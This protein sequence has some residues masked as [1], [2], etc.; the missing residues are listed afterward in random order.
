MNYSFKQFKK[1]FPTDDACLEYIF[2]NRYG[3]NY[4]CPRCG[5]KSFYRVKNRKCYAC[6]CGYQVSPTTETIFHKSD[7]KL[8]DWF[9]AIYLMSQSNNG[10]SAKEIQKHLGTT[11]KTAWRIAKLIRSLME[12]DSGMLNKTVEVDEMYIGGKRKQ[13]QR[14][15]NKSMVIGMVKRGGKVKAEYIKEYWTPAVLKN[16]TDNVERGTRLITD[17]SSIMSKVK[18]LGYL[19]DTIKHSDKKYVRGDIHTNTI[20]GFWSQIKR[21]IDGTY[22]AVSPKHLQNYINEFAYHYNHRL[23]SVS[24]FE[25]LL[26]RLCGQQGSGGYRMPL[27]EEVKIS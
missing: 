13:A 21:S 27:F 17:D 22:H 26:L 7:T 14:N 12:Q 23:S 19:H 8:T 15:D 2:K 4:K 1:D 20:E 3:L 9:F 18:R 24:V 10:V 25:D 6:S 16:L 11:Y 5:K